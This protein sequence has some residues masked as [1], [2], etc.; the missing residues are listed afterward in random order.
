MQR[1]ILWIMSMCH[2]KQDNHDWKN[3]RWMAL[4]IKIPWLPISMRGN[5]S[6]SNYKWVH[7]YML[8]TPYNSIKY[9]VSFFKVDFFSE[10]WP[11]SLEICFQLT[12][13][14]YPTIISVTQREILYFRPLNW[15]LKVCFWVLS[16]KEWTFCHFELIPSYLHPNTRYFCVCQKSVSVKVKAVGLLTDFKGRAEC[17]PR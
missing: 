13:I 8:P 3:P 15:D 2:H 11:Y 1:K 9:K 14:K 17:I 5:T 16:M 6:H 4:K 12:K 10:Y 7:G